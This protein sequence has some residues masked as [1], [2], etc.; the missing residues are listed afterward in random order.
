MAKAK[1]SGAST[2]DSPMYV[3]E[4][5]EFPPGSDGEEQRRAEIR[6]I[7][8]QMFIRARKRGRPRKNVEE[9]NH[10]A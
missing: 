9:L 6:E 7:L 4:Y 5:D 2:D 8:A 1:L 3:I 10:A